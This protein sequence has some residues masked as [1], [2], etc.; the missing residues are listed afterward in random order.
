ME[1][2][3]FFLALAV[4]LAVGLYVGQPFFERGGRRRSSAEAHEVS[5]LMAERDRVVNALQELDFDFQ[6]NKIPAEDYP[7]QRAELLKKGADVLK[8]LDALAPATTNGKATVDRIESA[9]A[10]RRADLSNAPIAVRTDDDVEAL[11]ATRRKARKDKS[12]GFCPRCGKPALASDRF[13]PH[14][15]KSIA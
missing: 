2:G 10:A 3:S 5:A 1:L 6:L 12:G 8:Q 11:I 4:F 13:C 14:C 7:A 15:G 9:V